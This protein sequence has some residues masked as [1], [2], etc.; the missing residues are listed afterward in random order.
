[1]GFQYI[2]RR[3]VGGNHDVKDRFDIFFAKIYGTG[4]I[5]MVADSAR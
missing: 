1:M 4:E 2:H 5:K 3:N